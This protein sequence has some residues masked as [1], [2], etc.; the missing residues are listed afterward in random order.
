[1]HTMLFPADLPLFL[2]RAMNVL[3]DLAAR[4]IIR[5]HYQ[6]PL[7]G[8]H[9]LACDLNDAL[10]AVFDLQ[11]APLAIEIADGFADLAPRK[12]L[13]SFFQCWVFLPD[14][15]IKISRPQSSFL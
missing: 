13:D 10:F 3:I 6:R 7:R 1:M 2:H 11:H 12:L 4:L 9:V 15:L 5:R 14:D 8:A